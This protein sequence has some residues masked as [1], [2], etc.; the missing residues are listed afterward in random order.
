VSL[1]MAILIP[2]GNA[3][4]PACHVPGTADT[5]RPVPVAVSRPARAIL[6]GQM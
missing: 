1:A 3:Y 6:A 2:V 4:E 5:P